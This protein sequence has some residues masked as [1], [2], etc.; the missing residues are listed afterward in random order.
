[1]IL[2]K[3]NI[4]HAVMGHHPPSWTV[5]GDDAE[6]AFSTLSILQLF[7]HLHTQWITS[8]GDSVRVIAGAVHPARNEL[9]WL[10]RYAAIAISVLNERQIALRIYPRRWSIDELM[11]IPD[12][13]SRYQDYRHYTIDVE[14]R[15]T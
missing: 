15:H 4:R 3:D 13:N 5:E 1:M 6:R 8:I 2:R 9:H 11:F 10:P 12:I 14:P 7:G